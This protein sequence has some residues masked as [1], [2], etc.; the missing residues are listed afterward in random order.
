LGAKRVRVPLGAEDFSVAQTI[1][2]NAAIAVANAVLVDRLRAKVT[3]LQLLRDRLLHAEEAERKRLAQD[4][5]DGALHTVL[6]LVRQAE[7]LVER[8]ADDTN[9]PQLSAQIAAIA[10]RGRLAAYEL[11]ATCA[12]LY[13]SELQHLGLVAA[14]ES[15]TEAVRLHEDLEVVLM[16]RSFPVD[17][18]LPEAV[19]DAIY[20]AAREGLDN[21][22]R[23]ARA[24]SVVVELRLEPG[25][26]SLSVED[27]G[28]GFTANA[29]ISSVA[30]LR[31]GHFG[32][33][34]MRERAEQLGGSLEISSGRGSG[35]R[36]CVRLPC[37]PVAETME[38]SA[39]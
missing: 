16:R 36:L 10:E 26:V 38:A 21:V 33:A 8:V 4:L 12:D 32:L 29:P 5:H 27:D 11:R 37:V 30:L 28:Q 17:C 23:H 18:R 13:P 39:A 1:A 14:L 24:R 2:S 22:S 31:T 19:E 34:C 20:R 25:G 6:A 3:E 35:A 9:G 15:L 7:G